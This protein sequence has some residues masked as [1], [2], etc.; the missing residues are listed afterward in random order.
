[1]V[2]A[3]QCFDAD[4]ATGRGL[5]LRLVLEEELIRFDG[6]TQIV[7]QA[8]AGAHLDVHG[9]G[10]EAIGAPPLGLGAVECHICTGQQRLSVGGIGSV[11]GDADA[12]AASD[13]VS[14]DDVRLAQAF[15]QPLGQ[16]AGIGRVLYVGLHDGEF[17]ATETGDGVV[18][19]HGGLQPLGHELEQRIAD[20]IPHRR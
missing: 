2:P 6:S 8:D 19:A 12:G 4:D 20:R 11:D 13:L 17:I 1:M 18:V 3:Y 15:E 14:A 9:V 16:Q 7:A 5:D 10:E